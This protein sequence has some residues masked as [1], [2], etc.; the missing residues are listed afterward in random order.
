MKWF[1][2]RHFLGGRFVTPGIVE[3]YGIES[4]EYSGID[5]VVEV[6]VDGVGKL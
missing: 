4:P 2:G 1:K 5:Q 3:K 6:D